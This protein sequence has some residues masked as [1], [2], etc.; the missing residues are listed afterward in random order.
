MHDV[1][2]PHLLAGSVASGSVGAG[3]ANSMSAAAAASTTAV[4]SETIANHTATLPQP[5][6]PTHGVGGKQHNARIVPSNIHIK[7]EIE[8]E[9]EPGYDITP[10]LTPRADL[11]PNDAMLT[12][13]AFNTLSSSG[14]DSPSLHNSLSSI[15]FN[16]VSSYTDLSSLGSLNKAYNLYG[17]PDT[18]VEA[19]I[20]RLKNG[21]GVLSGQVVAYGW[22]QAVKISG[23][24]RAAPARLLPA[25]WHA[26]EAC[27]LHAKYTGED[28]IDCL[29]CWYILQQTWARQFCFSGST[30]STLTDA[31]FPCV[32]K[33]MS[34][35]R[36]EM[37]V[38]ALRNI[39][40]HRQDPALTVL[41][42]S[43][44][45]SARDLMQ[46]IYAL[47]VV[48]VLWRCM[49]DDGRNRNEMVKLVDNILSTSAVWRWKVL[50]HRDRGPWISVKVAT[51]EALERLRL[52]RSSM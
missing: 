42:S 33:R 23:M 37:L 5:Q 30:M 10:P 9:L 27:A 51:L 18:T 38:E 39:A 41:G 4:F 16:F 45:C 25:L 7:E 14:T 26:T 21:D 36:L 3:V 24:T 34:V 52:M 32:I 47:V 12:S 44:G 50:L 46:P 49:Q 15:T 19:L 48:E 22:D 29:R 43:Y 31:I 28:V 40:Q 8:Y 13:A 11:R 17:S 2:S 20:A 6:N 35:E 1:P